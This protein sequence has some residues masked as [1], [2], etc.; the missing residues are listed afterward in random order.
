[1]EEFKA[2]ELWAAWAV[3]VVRATGEGQDEGGRSR[4]AKGEL[5]P[6]LPE[7]EPAAG[8][9]LDHFGEPSSFT[10]EMNNK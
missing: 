8:A 4:P 6:P 3:K 9:A 1:M 5:L 2:T 7:F 10:P